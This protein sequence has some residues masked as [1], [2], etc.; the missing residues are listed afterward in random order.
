MLKINDLTTEIANTVASQIREERQHLEYFSTMIPD[1]A[2]AII[3]RQN[4]MLRRY[5]AEIPA[6]VGGRC[7]NH[8]S[9]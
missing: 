6:L 8:H 2:N 9:T 3:D 4:L 5:M 1:A 7:S